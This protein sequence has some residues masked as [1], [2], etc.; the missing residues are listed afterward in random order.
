MWFA[1]DMWP[2]FTE[3]IAPALRATGY[4]AVRVDALQHN[5][6]IDDR[7]IAEIRHSSLVV[8]DFTGQRTGV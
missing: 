8:A 5:E 7:I 6:K 2:V 3:G 4:A 1:R